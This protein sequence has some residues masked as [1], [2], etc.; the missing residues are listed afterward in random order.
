MQFNSPTDGAGIVQDIYFNTNADGNSYPINDVT[1][2]VNRAYDT[3]VAKIFEADGRWEFDDQNATDLPIA[4]TQLITN[5]QDYSFDSKFLIVSRVEVKDQN[6]NWTALSPFSQSDIVRGGIPGYIPSQSL[7][8]FL[9]QPGIPQYYDKLANSIFLYPKPSYTQDASLK[10]Y[11]Q[12]NI[13]YFVPTDTTKT[14]GFNPQFHR[15]LSMEAS[16]DYAR[17]KN[18]DIG[19]PHGKIPNSFVGKLEQMYVDLQNYYSRK[20]KDENL[21]LH[22]R[23]WKFQ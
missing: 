8:D 23:K 12:R 18:L 5:Q 13:N 10:V 9:S 6:G 19:L 11:F 22:I 1:R 7:T 14:P 21:T 20:A 4:T 17:A 15:I 2:N 16:L 3:V